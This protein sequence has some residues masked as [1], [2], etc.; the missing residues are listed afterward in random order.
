MS[1]HYFT[2]KPGAEH[3]PFRF[4]AELRGKVYQFQSDAGVFSKDEIDAGTRLLINCLD[5]QPGDVVLDLGCGY[6]PLGL[7]AADLVGPGGR[8]YL[9]DV[10]ERA[11]EL[12]RQNLAANGITNAQV[13]LS[14]GLAALPAVEFDWVLCNPPIRAGKKVVYALLTEAYQALKPGGCLLVVI[15]TKQ[16]AKS[17]QTYLEEL[18]GGCTTLERQGG[19]RV[20]QCCKQL[21]T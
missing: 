11:V 9:V 5:L 17:L 10:N 13:F 21:R 2:P 18:A 4:Q 8:V 19:F 20:L 7:V 6:G 14:D 16:G 15:R 3:K 12:A 1:E